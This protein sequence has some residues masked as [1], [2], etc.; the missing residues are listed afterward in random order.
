M[1]AVSCSEGQGW[2]RRHYVPDGRH[3]A[4]CGVMPSFGAPWKPA[5]AKARTCVACHQ[6]RETQRRRNG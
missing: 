1:R 4:L 6:M 5:I 3:I 2:R